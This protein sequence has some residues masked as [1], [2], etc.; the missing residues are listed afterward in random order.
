MVKARLAGAGAPKPPGGR[1]KYDTGPGGGALRRAFALAWSQA[2]T[3]GGLAPGQRRKPV[4]SA[5][6]TP[7]P[8]VSR[9]SPMKP[10]LRFGTPPP[11]PRASP[12]SEPG[13]R[14]GR[15]ARSYAR[16]RR[17]Y[18]PPLAGL[19]QAVGRSASHRST[20]SRRQPVTPGPSL[21]GNGRCPF[22]D[23]LQSVTRATPS[24]FAK[25]A[26]RMTAGA[27]LNGA[28]RGAVDRSV[29]TPT[30]LGRGSRARQSS[31]S[32]SRD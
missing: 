20:S 24:I 5:L 18:G 17:I 32:E 16:G 28:G 9:R 26:G 30:P 11:V 10:R 12:P 19:A 8:R 21:I 7:G 2:R 14:P 13:C 27:P 25:S 15:V 23:H 6:E 1:V 4:R 22:R 3:L 29:L 31:V